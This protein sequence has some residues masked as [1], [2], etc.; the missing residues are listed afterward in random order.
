MLSPA[1]Y[2]YIVFFFPLLYVWL[3]GWFNWLFKSEAVYRNLM[4]KQQ[5]YGSIIKMSANKHLKI[6]KMIIDA[7]LI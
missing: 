7:I 1:L 3:V 6:S 5:R 4:V 2:Y